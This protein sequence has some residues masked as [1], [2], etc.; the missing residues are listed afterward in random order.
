[1]KGLTI[2]NHQK[3]VISPSKIGVYGDLYKWYRL[4]KDEHTLVCYVAMVMV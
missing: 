1:M 3:N 2:L 4:R